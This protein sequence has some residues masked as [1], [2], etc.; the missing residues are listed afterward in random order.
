MTEEKEH[1]HSP[2][3]YIQMVAGIAMW[4]ALLY[5]DTSRDWAAVGTIEGVVIACK[6]AFAGLLIY[7]FTKEEFIALVR[8]A[9]SGK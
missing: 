2:I 5:D 4:G 8:A 7:G 3:R 6:Y 1:R 9:R